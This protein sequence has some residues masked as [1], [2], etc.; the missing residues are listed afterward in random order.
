[1][2]DATAHAV[3]TFAMTTSAVTGTSKSSNAATKPPTFKG[4]HKIR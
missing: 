1:M 4:P 2:S 3:L